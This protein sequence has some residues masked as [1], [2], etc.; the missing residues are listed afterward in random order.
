VAN[1]SAPA[2][3]RQALNEAVLYLSSV[4]DSDRRRVLLA[5]LVLYDI[6]ATDADFL[7]AQAFVNE[8]QGG[9]SD[10]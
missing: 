6:R 9:E 5:L 8:I 7:A 2:H 3:A 4:P 1:L 10:G